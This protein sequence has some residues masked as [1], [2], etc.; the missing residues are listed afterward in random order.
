MKYPK[1]ETL[2][3]RYAKEDVPDAPELVGKVQPW[4]YRNDEL[5]ALGATGYRWHVEEKIHGMNIRVG[6][7]PRDGILRTEAAVRFGGRTDKA[8]LPAELMAELQR[9]FT[10]DLFT[11]VFDEDVRAVMLFGEGYGP[12]IQKGG[13]YRKGGQRFC[14]FDVLMYGGIHSVWLDRDSVCD[15]AARCG[16]GCAPFLGVYTALQ[17]VDLVQPG[18]LPS[19]LAARCALA[20]QAEGVVARSHPLMLDRRGRRIMFKLKL[21]DYPS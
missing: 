5:R 11:E 12:G 13:A 1:M 10:V 15:V 9:V 4:V 21:K 16:V 7:S 18:D 2:F 8:Q 3:R 20:S 17:V 14:L 19:V 6:Y